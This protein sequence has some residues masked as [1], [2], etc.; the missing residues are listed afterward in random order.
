MIAAVE[1]E[2]DREG[3]VEDVTEDELDTSCT[4]GCE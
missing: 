3:V 2:L 1:E 4:M